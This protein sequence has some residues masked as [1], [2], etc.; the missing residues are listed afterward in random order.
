ME[1]QAE[2]KAREEAGEEAEVSEV[3]ELKAGLTGKVIPLDEVP[4]D[5]FSQHIMGDGV[6]IEPENDTV[7]AP[8]DAKVGVVMEDSRH[9]CGLVFPNGAEL[10]IHVGVDTVDMNGDGFEL[11]VKE[12]DQVRAGQPLIRFDKAKIEAA[13]HPYVTVFIITEEGNAKDIEYMTGFEAV[14]GQTP[15]IRFN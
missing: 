2:E 7:V 8:A 1:E 12:G 11:F 4:D 15:V 6:A 3:K 14:A 5:V 10:L 9:A 13:G